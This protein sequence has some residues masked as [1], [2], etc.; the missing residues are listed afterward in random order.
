MT[1]PS[2]DG[3][4]VLNVCCRRGKGAFKMSAMVGAKGRVIGTDW[5]RDYIE[6]AKADSERAWRKNHLKETNMEFHVAYPENLME[7]GIGNNSVDMVYINNVMT[8]LY[9][10]G[11]ALKEFYRVLKPGGLLI[12]ETIFSSDKRDEEVVSKARAIGNSIQAAHTREEFVEMSNAAGF[13]A[14]ETV[15]EFEVAVDQGFK[16]NYKVD[17]ID[18]DEDV[19]YFAVALNIRKPK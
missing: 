18:S 11:E 6:E 8:L 4:R 14:P 12:C 9:D 5:S 16:A 15:D 19:K 10:Q 17:A 2:M 7:A 3:K 13:E 1:L